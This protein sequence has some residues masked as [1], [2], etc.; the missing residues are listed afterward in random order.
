M[1][2]AT[3]ATTICFTI[4]SLALLG[5]CGQRDNSLLYLVPRDSYSVIV[6]DWQSVRSDDSL[7]SLVRG[8]RIESALE[9]VGI[10]DRLLTRAILFSRRGSEVGFLLQGSLNERDQISRLQSNGWKKEAVDGYTAYFRADECVAFPVGNTVFIGA[11]EGATAVFRAL[12]NERDRFS[13]SI[14]FKRI[15]GLARQKS[16]PVRA[17]LVIPEDML[18]MTNA[19]QDVLSIL[20]LTSLANVLKLLTVAKGAAVSLKPKSGQM[21]AIEICAQMRDQEKAAEIA[22]LVKELGSL[23]NFSSDK[24]SIQNVKVA[25][26]REVLSVTMDVHK[27]SS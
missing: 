6:L 26:D 27:G 5:A 15:D 19:A 2:L 18:A 20:D 4:L 8:V 7:R 17:F 24:T 11:R 12:K 3:R 16:D 1:R 14:S 22:D 23:S 10:E 9:R 25:Q 13:S 21:Y